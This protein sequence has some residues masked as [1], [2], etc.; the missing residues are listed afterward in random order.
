MK[1]KILIVDDEP[2]LRAM[3]KTILEVEMLTVDLSL[4]PGRQAKAYVFSE[5]QI[6]FWVRRLG[7][8]LPDF[9]E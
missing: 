8:E 1:G 2:D 6:R 3:L 7:M 5:L 4:D 9:L